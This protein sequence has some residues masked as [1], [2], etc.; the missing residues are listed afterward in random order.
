MILD[1]KKKLEKALKEVV[2][3]IYIGDTY[4]DIDN[5]RIDFD[6]ED[7]DKYTYSILGSYG[8]KNCEAEENN[9][10]RVFSLEYLDRDWSLDYIKGYF[11][12]YIEVG[13]EL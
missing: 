7:D 2:D 5:I 12:K 1:E 6:Y 13:E 9:F 11:N 10:H 3:S 4:L 8:R